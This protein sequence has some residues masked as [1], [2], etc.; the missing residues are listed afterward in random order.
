MVDAPC[1]ADLRSDVVFDLIAGHELLEGEIDL[2]CCA[3]CH[4]GDD[5]NEVCCWLLAVGSK[6]VQAA[7]NVWSSEA[8]LN[9]EE[10][11]SWAPPEGA[12]AMAKIRIFS[13]NLNIT[14]SFL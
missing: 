13:V 6:Y 2:R 12:K 5:E 9:D 10:V 1:A 8:P 7:L 11:L 3:S 4:D 14:I